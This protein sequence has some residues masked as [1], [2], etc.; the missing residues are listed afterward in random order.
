MFLAHLRAT[1]NVAASARAAGFAPKTAWIRRERLPGFARAMDEAREDADLGLEF[2]LSVLA[3]GHK[4]DDYR[5]E[6]EPDISGE[7]ALRTLNFC[8]DRK[9]GKHSPRRAKPPSIEAVAEK[10]ERKVRAIKRH[11]EG[12][13]QLPRRGQSGARHSIGRVVS[14][15]APKDQRGTDSGRAGPTGGIPVERGRRAS[16]C[17]C[18]R[19]ASG[20]RAARPPSGALGENR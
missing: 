20:R 16:S 13:A 8:E 9:R 1:G 15:E 5:P 17:G 18:R 19:A 12:K 14:P 2:R 10:I 3:H 7:Q 6:G 11:R 4:G